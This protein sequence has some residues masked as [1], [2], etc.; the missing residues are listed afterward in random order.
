MRTPEIPPK[1]GIRFD[2]EKGGRRALVLEAGGGQHGAERFAAF[3]NQGAGRGVERP[4]LDFYGGEFD[5][6]ARIDGGENHFAD[7]CLAGSFFAQYVQCQGRGVKPFECRGHAVRMIQ[8]VS[9][10]GGQGVPF[11]GP[12]SQGRDSVQTP[13][14]L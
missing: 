13:D 11:D 6:D 4:K 1:S 2:F 12:A 10:P 14:G 3:E 5:N 8:E 7:I 9:I